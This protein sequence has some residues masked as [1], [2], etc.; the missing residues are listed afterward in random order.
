MTTRQSGENPN[1]LDRVKSLNRVSIPI[2]G[3]TTAK[4]RL[5]YIAAMLEELKAMSQ[6]ANCRALAGL[7]ERARREALRRTRVG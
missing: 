1:G 2:H 7:I 3:S 5:D 6:Q 4:D